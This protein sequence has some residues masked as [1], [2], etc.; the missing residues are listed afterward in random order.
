VGDSNA[1]LAKS[2][3][4]KSFPPA[5]NPWTPHDLRHTRLTELGKTSG[6]NHAVTCYQHDLSLD[7]WMATYAHFEASDT[8][9][10]SE[11]AER[12]AQSL[13]SDAV[14]VQPVV[15]SEEGKSSPSPEGDILP[16]S[17]P[18]KVSS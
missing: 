2:K 6:I 17:E 14:A 7:E 16:S 1:W 8:L 11:D 10:I 12:R 18:G 13:L 4:A 3:L 15:G 9:P 5:G